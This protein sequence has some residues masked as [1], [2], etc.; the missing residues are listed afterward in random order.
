[1]FA[2]VELVKAVFRRALA[3]PLYAVITQGEE[4]FV[5]I[6]E[7]GRAE[8]RNIQLGILADWQVQVTSGLKPGDRVVVVGHRFV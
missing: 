6:E 7:D 3:V 1:M 8:R 4:R 2:R 5:Y